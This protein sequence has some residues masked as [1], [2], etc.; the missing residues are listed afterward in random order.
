METPYQ[1][2]RWRFAFLVADVV[3]HDDREHAVDVVGQLHNV[4]RHARWS[5][6]RRAPAL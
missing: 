6:A 3:E 5:F 1:N 2:A 4:L